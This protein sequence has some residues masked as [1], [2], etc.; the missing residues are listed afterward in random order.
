[1]KH[2]I[3]IKSVGELALVA[4][5]ILEVYSNNRIFAFKG[6]MGSGKTTFIKSF[7]AELGVHEDV[8]SPTFSIVNEYISEQGESLYHFDFYRIKKQ[9]EI[10][11]IGSDEYFYSGNY[12]FLEWPELVK[13]LLPESIVYISI[14]E[15]FED[16]SRII[17]F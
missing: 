6:S 14:E 2:K 17:Q 5:K 8:T 3:V 1:M 9:E 7:C 10:M 16:G 12:C 15:N 11:D 4:K 13:E